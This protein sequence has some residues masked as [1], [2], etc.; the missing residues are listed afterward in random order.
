[1]KVQGSCMV[2][3]LKTL[4]LLAA[5]LLSY[6]AIGDDSIYLRCDA[7]SIDQFLDQRGPE[8]YNETKLLEIDKKSKIIKWDKYEAE[9][10]DGF[11]E[12][13]NEHTVF[14]F[15]DFVN[16]KLDINK[17]TGVLDEWITYLSASK[18]NSFF[19]K[20]QCKRTKPLL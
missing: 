11:L 9:L 13:G 12:D 8:P 10:Y 16:I 2:D 19:I 4:I 20:Y 6:S 17:I 5:S 7:E 3:K 15:T 18:D 14:F 1:M